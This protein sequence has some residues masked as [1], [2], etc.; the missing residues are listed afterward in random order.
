MMN[1]VDESCSWVTGNT[2]G[3]MQDPLLQQFVQC[4]PMRLCL[5]VW[6]WKVNGSPAAV[7]NNQCVLGRGYRGGGKWIRR[8]PLQDMVC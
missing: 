2:K 5:C 1:Y 3:L 7:C 4:V 8:E 6:L